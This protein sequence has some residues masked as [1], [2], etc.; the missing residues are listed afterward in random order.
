MIDVT[1]LGTAATMPLP[2][3]ALTSVFLSCGGHSILFDCGEGTQTAA[4]KAHVSLMKTDLIALTHYHG[5]HIFGLPGL[6]QTMA[7]LGRTQP[8]YLT[9]PD[10]L[11]EAMRPIIQ[12]SG[13]LPFPVLAFAP[14]NLQDSP[15]RDNYTF[16]FSD[17][18]A[19][20]PEEASL[21]VFRTEH[22]VPSCGYSFCLARPGRFDPERALA[23]QIPQR[24]WGVLQHGDCV[25]LADGRT[26]APEEV[27]GPERKGLKVVFSGDTAPCGGLKNAAE[28]ADLLLC[29]AT[30]G[31]DSQQGQADKYGHSTF[32]RTAALA[33]D[34]GVKRLWLVHFSQIMERP[35][36]Y[37]YYASEFFP[38]AVCGT[39]GMRI[40]LSFEQD[41]R[42]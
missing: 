37:L 21:T 40:R 35:E 36:D 20:W 8:L 15:E 38:E 10:G 1:L 42:E 26:I 5:D 3:R 28:S 4:R 11:D 17:Y 23:L 31:E 27:L 14:M 32:S 30:Y 34:A 22:R 41:R 7:C 19:G 39:D 12:L 2:D 24:L 9:G 29:D 6:L 25:E 13:A 16:H 33:R 18:I